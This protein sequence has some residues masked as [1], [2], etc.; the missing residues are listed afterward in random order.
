MKQVITGSETATAILNGC[1]KITV[2]IE[3]IREILPHRGRMLLLDYLE[4][5]QEVVSGI[6]SVT[7]EV[8]EGHAVLEGKTI[9]KGSDYFDMAA[10]VMGVYASQIANF[11]MTK[12]CVIH[13]YGGAD[14][15]KPTYPG[16][17][18]V[19]EIKVFDIEIKITEHRNRKLVVLTGKNFFARVGEQKKAQVLSVEALVI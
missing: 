9:F 14:F 1:A 6:F 8:C 10:Q 18:L 7:E 15:F 17:L 13:H 11:K 19:M 5:T 3:R 12:G 16:D 2:P 4:I